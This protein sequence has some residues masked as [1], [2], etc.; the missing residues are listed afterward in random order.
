MGSVYPRGKK[1]WLRFKGPDGK[2]TQSK[3]D[4]L[5]G[6]EVQ[7]RLALRQLEDRIA[8]KGEFEELTKGPLTVSAYAARWLEE[9]EGL[10]EDHRSDASRLRL[11]VLPAIGDMRLE[12][13]RPRHL[14]ELFRK[15]RVTGLLAPKTIYNVHGVVKALFR[16]AHLGDLVLS[17]PCIL[18]KHQLGKNV[19]KDPTWRE[20]TAN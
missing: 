2:W 3:T 16:D 4:F 8:A 11:H 12:D 1:L 6:Q 20:C 7:A 18:T 13:V 15:L 19:D 10:I 9:R 5:V 14:I 17:S